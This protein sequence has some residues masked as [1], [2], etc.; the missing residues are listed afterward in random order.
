MRLLLCLGLALAVVGC[1]PPALTELPP[2]EPL[3]ETE[4]LL[5]VYA[6]GDRELSPHLRRSR[7]L[8][9]TGGEV[10]P[11]LEILLFSEIDGEREL[12][13][14]SQKSRTALTTEEIGL[15][16]APGSSEETLK[17]LLSYARGIYPE[18]ETHLLISGSSG[19][20]ENL[21]V[22]GTDSGVLEVGEVARA[23]LGP[24]DPW[25]TSI[26]LES[27]YGGS[28]SVLFELR[29][30]A[31]YLLSSP[32]PVELDGLSVGELFRRLNNGEGVE[33]SL[34][35]ALEK[36]HELIPG[37]SFALFD[38]SLVDEVSAALEEALLL[39]E[40]ELID[41]AGDRVTLRDLLFEPTPY[42]RSTGP[43]FLSLSALAAKL[44][45]H[46]PGLPVDSF[47]E[48][49]ERLLL[50]SWSQNDKSVSPVLY[51]VSL[52]EEGAAAGHAGCYLPERPGGGAV[53]FAR[54][55]VWAPRLIEKRGILYLLWYDLLPPGG[56]S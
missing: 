47:Q 51:F 26:V 21:S 52:D 31:R 8:L 30:S 11:G 28:M 44:A 40:G 20:D 37:A 24:G 43:F 54:S 27:S 32:G 39:L 4:Q 29:Q 50:E 55:T 13:G 49:A 35:K 53:T 7:D 18:A 41:G 19:F 10:P 3:P 48:E 16:E 42:D 46:Y 1:A 17:S 14:R 56:A 9:L 25:L 33:Y 34:M 15:P 22:A 36:S 6:L 12:W 5:I 45:A 2:E 23:A 38:L